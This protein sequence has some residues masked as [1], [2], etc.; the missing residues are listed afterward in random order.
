[1]KAAPRAVTRPATAIALD[2]GT[3]FVKGAVLDLE[4]R[5]LAHTV[6]VPFP[7]PLAGL[8]PGHHE[9][10]PAAVLTVTEELLGSILTV[11]P[12]AEGLVLSSQMHALVLVDEAGASR[13]NIVTWQDQRALT[14]HPREDATFLDVLTQ[15]IGPAGCRRTGNDLWPGRPLSIL[16]WLRETGTLPR[17]VTPLSLPDFVLA[18]LG[19]RRDSPPATSLTHAAAMAALDVATGKWDHATLAAAGLDGLAWP[20]IATE[21]QAV[22]HLAAGGRD[23]PCF[24]PLGD[25]QASLLGAALQA[26]ELSVNASTGSQVA[27]ITDHP[28]SGPFT[29]RPYVDGRFLSTVV[30][31]P[32]GRALQALVRLLS[33]LAQAEGVTLTDAWGT[34]ERAAEAVGATDLR[35]DLAFFPSAFGHR[36]ALTELHEGNLTVGHLFRAAYEAMAERYRQCAD[37]VAPGGGWQRLV[38]SGALL[39]QSDLLRRLVAE[40]FGGAAYRL[41]P[42]TEDALGGLLAQALACTGR[43]RSCAEA[44]AT[45]LGAQLLAR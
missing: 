9:I 11:A 6:R 14:R 26:D 16:F 23:L 8:P 20:P 39:Q 2:L 22:A 10:D 21:R 25:Q 5:R 34:I 42:T 4:A 30:H 41:A 29:A 15:R 7:A 28:E 12:N 18:R 38:F 37:R 33:E 19:R 32:A 35:A 36:G 1:M 40:R 3:T 45:L 27:R 43:A 13:S 24:A 31:V 17:R 44:A